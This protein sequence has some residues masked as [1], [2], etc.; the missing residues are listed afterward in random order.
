MIYIQFPYLIGPANLWR[1]FI[2]GNFWR[3]IYPRAPCPVW[4]VLALARGAEVPL[5]SPADRSLC[6]CLGPAHINTGNLLCIWNSAKWCGGGRKQGEE[7]QIAGASRR[8]RSPEGV[9]SCGRGWPK[10]RGAFYWRSYR[11]GTDRPPRPAQSEFMIRLPCEVA[12]SRTP[13]SPMWSL[14]Q[15]FRLRAWHSIIVVRRQTD[16]PLELCSSCCPGLLLI[17]RSPFLPCW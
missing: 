7:D 15:P 6:I 14:S 8:M 12:F 3:W 1:L 5:P 9:L 16:L 13:F 17:P 4:E 11:R 2:L 10:A